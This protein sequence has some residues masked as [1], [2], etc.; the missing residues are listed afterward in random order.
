MINTFFLNLISILLFILIQFICLR[1]WYSVHLALLK[2]VWNCLV[3]FS[4]IKTYFYH[5]K[6]RITKNFIH[7]K[8]STIY[9]EPSINRHSFAVVFFFAHFCHT[10]I[11]N[12]T[13]TNQDDLF[14]VTS[15]LFPYFFKILMLSSVSYVLL[16]KC[17]KSIGFNIF[18]RTSIIIIRLFL[19]SVKLLVSWLTDYWGSTVLMNSSILF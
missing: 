13:E 15:V 8:I 18:M 9:S 16:I 12:I 6:K 3:I 14:F 17:G 19:L 10:K 5:T 1:F 4:F 11:R 2:M 7:F